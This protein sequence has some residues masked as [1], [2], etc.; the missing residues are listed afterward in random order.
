MNSMK[1][2]VAALAIV[3]GLAGCAYPSTDAAPTSVETSSSASPEVTASAEDVAKPTLEAIPTPSPT[4]TQEPTIEAAPEIPQPALAPAPVQEVLPTPPPVAAAPEVVV[5]EALPVPM[6]EVAPQPIPA[7][8][9]M[10]EVVPAPAPLSGMDWVNATMA[11]YG[12]YPHPQTQ[13]VIGTPPCGPGSDGCL[14]GLWQN[15]ETGE[16]FVPER[17][18]LTLTIAPHAVGN[19]F[20]LFHEI[21]HSWGII[22]ECAADQYS[23]NVHGDYSLRSSAC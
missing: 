15:D 12:V 7:P 10:P 22:D 14:S 17:A 4:P 23:Y 20:V 3:V 2:K 9:P 5:P 8:V 18:V 19:E 11:K 16:A 1:Q 6:P 21:A 13:I